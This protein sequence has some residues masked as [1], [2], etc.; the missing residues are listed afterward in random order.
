MGTVFSINLSV[1]WQIAD[2]GFG[3]FREEPKLL[4]TT[5][6]A[7]GLREVCAAKGWDLIV[8]SDKEGPNSVFQKEIETAE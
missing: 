7:L 6:N 3:C 4:G 8:T 5:E 2:V 1:W